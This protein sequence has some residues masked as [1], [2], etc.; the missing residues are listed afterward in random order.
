L[1]LKEDFGEDAKVMSEIAIFYYRSG[2]LKDFQDIKARM[3]KEHSTDKALYEFLIKA[4]LLDEKSLEIPPLVEKLIAIEPGEL[5]QMMTAGKV[6]FEAGK[7]ADAA[8]WFA[9][10]KAKMSSYPKIH[11]YMAKIDYLSG[12]TDSALKLIDEGMKAN[13]ENDDDLV[14]Q[15]QIYQTKDKLVEAENLYKRAQKINPK[16]YDAIVGLADLSTK[17]NN[18]DL[19]LDLYKRATKLRQDEP[20]VHKKIGDVYRQLGQGALAIESY[21][22]YLDMDPESPHKSNLEAYINLM[23]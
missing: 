2:K 16:S 14:L 13:G 21:K 12:D 8:K 15:A 23:K 11:Y 5:E 17:R 1:S 4:A 6:L 3:E 18:H 7:I 20:M 22:L 9:R 19:A 10:V